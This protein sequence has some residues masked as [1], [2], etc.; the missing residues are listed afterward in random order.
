[1]SCVPIVIFGAPLGAYVCS[2]IGRDQLIW[3]L[4]FLIAIEVAST[5]WIIPITSN[6]LTILAILTVCTSLLFYGLIRYRRINVGLVD[7]L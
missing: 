1:M 7:R 3:F 4:L 2:K 6:R 5:L